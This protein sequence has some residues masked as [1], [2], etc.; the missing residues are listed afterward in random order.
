MKSLATCK[1]SEFLRQTNRIRK[2]VEK[3]LTDTDIMN[4]RKRLPEYESAKKGASIE[5]RKEVIERNAA[6]EREQARKNLSA[7]LDAILE[8]HP[9]ETLEVLALC[10]FVEPQDADNH[11]VK[12]YIAVLS[13][14]LNDPDVIGFFTSLARLAPTST[15]NASVA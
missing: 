8:E 13:E 9:D 14:L 1:P 2:S 10:C 3:W 5:E 7:I 6:L 11:T 12:E 4:I 15:P